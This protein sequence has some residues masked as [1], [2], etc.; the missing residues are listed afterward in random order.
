MILL[1]GGTSEGRI[2]AERFS[3]AGLKLIYSV[4][5]L[6]RQPILRVSVITGGFTQ[7][8]GLQRY[9]KSHK[10]RAVVDATHPYALKISAT[11]QQ[12]ALQL[13]LPYLRFQRPEWQPSE[14]DDWRGYDRLDELFTALQGY[15]RILFTLGAVAKA[16][17]AMLSGADLLLLRRAVVDHASLANVQNLK[18]IG[19]FDLSSELALLRKHRIEVLV[20]KQSGGEATAAKLE[21]ARVLSIPVCFLNRP[22]PVAQVDEFESI[23]TLF[24]VCVPRFSV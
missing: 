10:I 13:G 22:R 2:L 5:G 11:A 15:R 6:V 4:A 16:R 24:A 9:L 19:P 18:A 14:Q 12:A 23:E 8:G 17:L 21:A 3:D 1:L 7:F 20:S